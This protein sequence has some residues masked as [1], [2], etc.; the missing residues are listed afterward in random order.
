MGYTARYVEVRSPVLSL[1]WLICGIAIVTYTL[2]HSLLGQHNYVHREVPN[3]DVTF[4]Q[5]KAVDGNWWPQPS[6]DV[7][8]YCGTNFTMNTS[9][10]SSWGSQNIG[11]KKPGL[12]P[13]TYFYPSSNQMLVALSIAYGKDPQYNSNE[14][15]IYEE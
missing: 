10:G 3:M 15:F 4:W 9:D 7:L 12:T 2:I 11:C 13:G 1:V 6:G 8:P 14:V 5:D